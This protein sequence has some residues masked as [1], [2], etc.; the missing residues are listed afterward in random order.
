MNKKKV[1]LGSAAA[2]TLFTFVGHTMGAFLP[3][4]PEDLNRLQ[5]FEAMSKTPIPMPIGIPR[6]YAEVMMG[7]S[8][9][10]SV[11]L[12]VA[13]ILFILYAMGKENSR[14]ILLLNGLGL[15]AVSLLCARYFFPL[16]A[17]CLGLAGILA[18]MASKL[19]SKA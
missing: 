14:R 7:S 16:P 13:G 19:D 2:L 5:T 6:S 18:C 3:I 12:L 4:P 17:I 15:F 10:V 8:L 11:F 9:T 1:Y